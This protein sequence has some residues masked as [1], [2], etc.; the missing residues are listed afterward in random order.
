MSSRQN[1]D[2]ATNKQRSKVKGEVGFSEIKCH[3]EVAGWE[4][5]IELLYARVS[6]SVS[7]CVSVW[8]RVCVSVWV[9]VR[10][11]DCV[12]EWVRVQL[13]QIC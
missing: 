10:V 3:M 9:Y 5:L 6:E 4:G 13:V 11:C 7:E 12:S 2:Q 8:V 1:G